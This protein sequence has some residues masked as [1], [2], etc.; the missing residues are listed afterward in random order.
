MVIKK[1]DILYLFGFSERTGNH[2][3]RLLPLLEVQ[4]SKG[5]EIGLVLIHDGVI[6]VTVNSVIPKTIDELLSLNISI[7]AM[8]PDMNARGIP[9]EKLHSKIKPVEYNELVD[10]LDSAQKV[11]S[12]M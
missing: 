9:V 10:I 4:K 6:G 2:L 7:F 8:I 3:E 1:M 11:I 12:W 5:S